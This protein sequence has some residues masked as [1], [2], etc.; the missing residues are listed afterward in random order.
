MKSFKSLV[1]GTISLLIASAAFAAFPEKEITLIVPYSAGGGSDTTARIFAQFANK[2]FPKP[3]VVENYPGGGGAIGQ[4]RGAQAVPDGYTLTQITTS[5]T[6]QPWIKK[7]PYDYTSF[8]PI[9]QLVD[10]P[11]VLMVRKDNTALDTAEKFIAFAKANP[12]KLRI[13]TSGKGS[14]DQFTMMMFQ[15]KG[16]FKLTLVPFGADAKVNLLGG[17][18]DAAA[19]GPE[20]VTDLPDLKAL[21]VFAEKRLPELPDVPTAKELGID[22]TSSVWRGIALPKGAP[23]DVVAFY[24]KVIAKV[25]ADPEFIKTMQNLGM[26]VEY[27]ESDDFAAKIKEKAEVYK[28]LSAQ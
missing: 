27:L 16:G 9:A 12:G 2:Y 23:D 18:V 6:I 14:T 3:I 1:I 20:D 22:W 24:D 5:L 28:M 25:M 21:V 10:T 11:D 13:G 15:E 4:T 17:H 26:N 7:V 19:G 8:T